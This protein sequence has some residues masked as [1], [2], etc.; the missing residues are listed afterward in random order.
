M[1]YFVV[2]SASLLLVLCALLAGCTSPTASELKPAETTATVTVPVATLTPAATA[3][4]LPR[5]SETLPAEQYVDLQISKQRPDSSIHLVF[6]GGKGEM[7]VQNVFLKVTLSD[8]EV[9]ALYMNDNLRQPRRG[10]ELV[11]KGT[12]GNDR[13]EVYVTTSGKTY[14]IIDEVLSNPYYL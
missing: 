5:A 9:I 3:T 7:F 11:V 1:K 13:A 6:N 8:G 14:K 10:D 2:L 4:A 12:R